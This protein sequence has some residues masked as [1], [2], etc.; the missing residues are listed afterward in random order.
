[1]VCLLQGV[2]DDEKLSLCNQLHRLLQEDVFQVCV[3]C[4]C[5]CVCVC[6]G[7]LPSGGVWG[8]REEEQSLTQQWRCES[9]GQLIH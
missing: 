4:V 1:M 2:S 8:W 6:D 3:W 5:V 9:T 7:V